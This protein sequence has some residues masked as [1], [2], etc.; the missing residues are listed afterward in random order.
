MIKLRD[1]VINYLPGLIVLVLSMIAL[2][3]ALSFMRETE[4]IFKK[5]EKISQNI[6]E[7]ESNYYVF[8]DKFAELLLQ[9][10]QDNLNQAQRALSKFTYFYYNSVKANKWV[11]A[12]NK[13]ERYHQALH[14]IE[15][16]LIAQT[17][18]L[19]DINSESFTQS[20]K[21]FY[22]RRVHKLQENIESLW[23]I[24]HSGQINQNVYKKLKYR[25]SFLYW[26]VLAMGLMG[27]VLVVLNS[28]KL[29]Q[30]KKANREKQTH[31][32]LLQD[33]FVAME[34]SSDGIAI[35]DKNGNLT[36]MNKA[37]TD[38]HGISP[39]DAH[40]YI[41]RC[42]TMLY[43]K[44]GRDEIQEDVMPVLL[45]EGYWRGEKLV[46]KV[47]GEVVYAELSLKK[48]LDGGFIGTARDITEREKIREEKEE[49]Q[50][51]FYQAQKMEAI[52]RL[53]GGIAHDFNNILAAMNGYAEFLTDDLKQG[54][55]QHKFAKN[56][57]QAGMQAKQL[58]DQILEFS[59][60]KNHEHHKSINLLDVLEDAVAMIEATFPKTIEIQKDIRLKRA[61]IHGNGTQISQLIMNLFVNAKDAMD[62]GHGRLE[63]CLDEADSDEYQALQVTHKE[64]QPSLAPVRIEDVEKLHT[65]LTLNKIKPD[66]SYIRLIIKDTGSGMSRSVME[67]I[68]EPF[69]T[70]KSV[71]KGTGLGLSTVHGVIVNYG[72]AMLI[73]SKVNQGTTFEI[74]IPKA[75]STDQEQIINQ[76]AKQ[77]LK[78]VRALLVEDQPEVS[79][80]MSL[81]LRRLGVIVDIAQNGA[82]AL[83]MIQESLEDYDVVITDQNM[84]KLTGYELVEQVHS[85]FPNLPFILISGYSEEKLKS[86]MNNHPAIKALLRK[87]VAKKILSET[88]IRVLNLDK[89]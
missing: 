79:D 30:L 34:S 57:L 48:L 74:L 31:L 18:T 35:V 77:S 42:W 75:P 13:D 3:S 85:D 69:F 40:E 62:G 76:E 47:N 8:E 68:F 46:K 55:E 2:Y 22:L 25:Q 63:I 5:Y 44:A 84:P 28:S 87:P 12:I 9:N 52:G 64:D 27:F 59:R 58:V 21:M 71:D 16:A 60:I 23:H 66:T 39:S 89:H 37:L 56:I 72:G 19:E 10:N 20:Q 14:E 11:F 24:L 88:L 51:Q 83:E 33:R 80:V 45:K 36:Y 54:S 49:I 81:S 17:Q 61:S 78:D 50:S 4:D 1:K 32:K 6:L 67:H 65:R 53:A 26:S 73:D 15:N 41:G 7:L 29:K 70:T 43:G 82:E 86:L 38:M